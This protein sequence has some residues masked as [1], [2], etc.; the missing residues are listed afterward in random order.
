MRIQS[1]W[2]K[3]SK[4]IY[5]YTICITL[6]D[7]I[8]LYLNNIVIVKIKQDDIDIMK[9]N[10]NVNDTLEGEVDGT[11]GEGVGDNNGAA[12]PSNVLQSVGETESKN[13]LLKS[14][15]HGDDEENKSDSD[16][17]ED[18]LPEQCMF[19]SLFT[20]IAWGAFASVDERLKIILTSDNTKLSKVTNTTMKKNDR[21]EN[22][23]SRTHDS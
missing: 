10:T 1:V 20:F 21:A 2:K 4:D 19:K 22:T 13:L 12:M 5:Q 7:M 9:N 16:V 6:S 18:N 17:E 15:C 14:L 11:V 3:V 8:H 23:Y